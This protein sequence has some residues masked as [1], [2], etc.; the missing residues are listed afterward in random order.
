MADR[1]EK[2]QQLHCYHAFSD[3]TGTYVT[4]NHRENYSPKIVP[5]NPTGSWT[6][7]DRARIWMSC[8]SCHHSKWVLLGITIDV[9][10]K[11]MIWFV[12]C[13]I[14]KRFAMLNQLLIRHIGAFVLLSDNWGV[15]QIVAMKIRSCCHWYWCRFFSA[16]VFRIDNI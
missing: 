15:Y 13:N 4:K 9:I 1:G 16:H 7:C 5:T 14:T 8:Q 3:S 6:I 2:L 11:R 12:I 10:L